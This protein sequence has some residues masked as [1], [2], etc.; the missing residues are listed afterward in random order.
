MSYLE[1]LN[2]VYK[3]PLLDEMKI[4][5]NLHHVPIIQ[6]EGLELLIH[7]I[8]IS[9]ASRV[10]EI[11]SAIGYS[12]LQMIFRTGVHVTTIERDPEMIE[13]AKRHFT[14]SGKEK[15]VTLIEGD[16]LTIPNDIFGLYDVI[17]IDA[18]K[19][20]YIKFF[21]KYEKYLA[22]HGV[23]FTDN[24][25]FHDMV[26]KDLVDKN[27]RTRQLVN[28]IHQFNEWVTKKEEYHTHIYEIGD[29]IALSYLK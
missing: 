1:Q 22:P 9:K 21:E 3:N 12:A 2:P 20:Q 26:G 16:A 14:T 13:L 5:A 8:E 4:Y 7:V 19:G 6:D 27:K 23:I 10:L 11:G 17:F 29:G 15:N 24:L 25:L 18:A 28:K